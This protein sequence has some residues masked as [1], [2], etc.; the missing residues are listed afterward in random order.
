M[1]VAED[2]I[3]LNFTLGKDPALYDLPLTL[4]TQVPSD[5]GAC[6]VTQGRVTKS[7][8]AAEGVVQYDATPGNGEI[9]LTP[10]TGS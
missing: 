5:W 8:Q 9:S 4:R 6:L 3:C 1:E 10:C 7:Y 2:H